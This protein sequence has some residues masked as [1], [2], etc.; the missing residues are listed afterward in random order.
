MFSS[1]FNSFQN[2]RFFL[3]NENYHLK[4]VWQGL[5][6][7]SFCVIFCHSEVKLWPKCVW[8]CHSLTFDLWSPK[9]YQVTLEL[10]IDICANGEGF[11][12]GAPE[13]SQGQNW[14]YSD[15]CYWALMCAMM[16]HN[17]SHIVVCVWLATE[18]CCRLWSFLLFFPTLVIIYKAP[19]RF[20]TV[21]T[22]S[23]VWKALSWKKKSY[24]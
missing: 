7:I 21:A 24:L 17:G 1:T 23:V 11:P 2:K 18:R 8:S 22:V 10:R 12:W 3:F 14:A 19:Y 4:V 16:G 20:F 9:C 5:Y 13:Y 15:R 6:E